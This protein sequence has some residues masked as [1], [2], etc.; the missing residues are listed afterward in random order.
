MPWPQKLRDG[1]ENT[2]RQR[3]RASGRPQSIPWLTT[4]VVLLVRGP[5]AANSPA[6]AMVAWLEKLEPYDDQ[7]AHPEATE[8]VERAHDGPTPSRDGRHSEAPRSS[9]EKGCGLVRGTRHMTGAPRY[10]P[11]K[12]EPCR[13][14]A[15]EI[16]ATSL[17]A[18]VSK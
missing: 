16:T 9:S 2:S 8:H 17:R 15:R 10:T 6:L 11:T 1:Q 13:T 4:V 12:Q 5:A 3:Q 14:V 18:A 7:T